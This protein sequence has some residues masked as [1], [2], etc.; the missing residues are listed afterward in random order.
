ML[1]DVPLH[2]F[3]RARRHWSLVLAVAGFDVTPRRCPRTSSPEAR[4][5][6]YG[7]D[8]S[9]A[10]PSI[11]RVP[12]TPRPFWATGVQ[13]RR[14]PSRAGRQLSFE[15]SLTASSSRGIT[16]PRSCCVGD[17]GVSLC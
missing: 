5:F 16:A 7:I 6:R 2:A 17:G 1:Q 10:L 15:V 9:L 3:G 13:H 14:G 11:S 12:N 8:G 4:Q